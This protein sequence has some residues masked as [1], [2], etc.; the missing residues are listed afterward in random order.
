MNLGDDYPQKSTTILFVRPLINR[1]FRR[2]NHPLPPPS[3]QKN[4]PQFTWKNCTLAPH[5]F[6]CNDPVGNPR[7]MTNRF[8][9]SL[10]LQYYLL[11]SFAQQVIGKIHTAGVGTWLCASGVHLRIY[12][13][14]PGIFCHITFKN[15]IDIVVIYLSI[16]INV[17]LPSL[18][19]SCT[20]IPRLPILCITGKLDI[21]LL[22]TLSSSCIQ[23]SRNHFQ[24]KNCPIEITNFGQH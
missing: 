23:L 18:I 3:P 16:M 5:R 22:S 21:L 9:Y 6:I 7:S 24:K 11:D 13:S 17:H 15:L 19:Q 1:R 10:Q 8:L 20:K 4:I 12:E 2:C 14:F